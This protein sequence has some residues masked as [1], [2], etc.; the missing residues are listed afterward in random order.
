MKRVY[1]ISVDDF[2]EYIQENGLPENMSIENIGDEEY[3]KACKKYGW[4]LSL[5]EFVY[6][7]NND[8]DLAPTTAYHYIKIF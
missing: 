1:C 5:D 2:F 8:F 3:A 4:D 7:F 6:Q